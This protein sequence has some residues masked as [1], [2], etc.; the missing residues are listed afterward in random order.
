VGN[1]ALYPALGPLLADPQAPAPGLV[2]VDETL[3][4]SANLPREMPSRPCWADGMGQGCKKRDMKG[5][6]A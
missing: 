2:R 6:Q 5:L 4:L 1:Y 3:S